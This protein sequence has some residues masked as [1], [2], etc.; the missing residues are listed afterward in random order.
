MVKLADSP[1]DV[2]AAPGCV[3]LRERFGERYKVVYEESYRADRGERAFAPDPWLMTIPCRYGHILPWTADLLAV[4]VDGHPIMAGII[5]R[6]SCC[7][8]VQDGDFGELTVTFALDDFPKIAK[9]MRP[10]RRPQLSDEERDR[11][12]RVLAENIHGA[13]ENPQ[14]TAQEAAPEGQRVSGLMSGAS[15]AL[16]L[17]RI[18]ASPENAF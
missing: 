17:S 7:Q 12:R 1:P 9:I 2:Q 4:S 18:G 5:R 3:N 10:H 14:R 15:D 13:R 11:R 6:L 8:V 16:A